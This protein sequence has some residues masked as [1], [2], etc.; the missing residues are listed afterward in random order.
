MMAK[1]SSAVPDAPFSKSWHELSFKR[2]LRW[3][4]ENG[5]DR[6]GWTTG[7]QQAERYDLRKHLD[8]LQ[9]DHNPDG[10]YDVIGRKGGD[11]VVAKE[12]LKENE[13]AD[14][15]GKDMA[16]K[17]VDKVGVDDKNKNMGRITGLDLKVGGEGMKGFYDKILPDYA[18]KYAK[19]WGAKVGE[20]GTTDFDKSTRPGRKFE[21]GQLS[22]DRE[23]VLSK[24]TQMAGNS[25]GRHDAGSEEGFIKDF[26]EQIAITMKRYN[27]TIR[28]ALNHVD[29]TYL[30]PAAHAAVDRVAAALG[31]KMSKEKDQNNIKVHSIDITPE[32]KKSVLFEGQ[33][34]SKSIMPKNLPFKTQ[35]PPEIDGF[36]GA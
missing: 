21:G 24:L 12:R 17:I 3:A 36:I 8:T 31:G 18:N 20:A 11:K 25:K 27:M 28:E 14:F 32:M 16:Q 19:K 13:L 30:D 5:Y 7:E 22:Y 34:I 35:A 1:K 29:D 23:E 33:P 9:W 4:A 15:I 6:L 10:S 2:M 26:V